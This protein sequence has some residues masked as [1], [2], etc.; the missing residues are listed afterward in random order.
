MPAI[1]SFNP[2]TDVNTS[3]DTITISNHGFNALDGVIYRNGGGTSVG[4]LV[5]GTKYYVIVV[6]TNNLKLA[7][8]EVK[9]RNS[10]VV[11]ILNTGAGTVHT[12]EFTT[13]FPKE[14]AVHNIFQNIRIIGTG[15][16]ADGTTFT[17]ETNQDYLNIIG[18]AGV[19]FTAIDT[20]SKT[21]TL[22]ATQYDF[23]VPLGTT[24]LRLFSDSGDDQ[25]IILTPARGIAITRVGSQELEFESFGVTETDTLQT[26]TQRGSITNQDL[27]M[28]NLLVAKVESIP[29]VDGVVNYTTTGTTGTAIALTGNGTLDFPLLFSPDYFTSTETDKDIY[30]NFQSPAAQGTLSYTAVYQTEST[31]TTGSVILQRND[32]GG[33]VTI[34]NIS[35]TQQDQSYTIDGN[36]AELSTSTIDYR[37]VFSWTG[38]SDIVTSRVRVTYELENVPG[39]EII[40][41]DTDNEVLTLGTLNGF[42]NIRGTVTF[43]DELNTDGLRLYNNN[44]SSINSDSNIVIVPAG[45]GKLE[46]RNSD[47]FSTEATVNLFTTVDTTTINI[48][49]LDGTPP[50]TSTNFRTNVTVSGDLN[51]DGGDITTNQ[52][53]FNLLNTNATTINAFGAAETINLGDATATQINIGSATTDINLGNIDINGNTIDTNDSTGITFTPV[54]TFNTDVNAENDL[55]VTQDFFVGK[56]SFLT[57]NLTVQENIIVVGEI[58]SPTGSFNLL[59]QPN[60][61]T[62][63]S[64]ANAVSIGAATGTTTVQHSLV[65]SG[66]ATVDGGNITTNQTTFNL[67]NTNAT[68]VNFAGAG[69]AIAIGAGT[70]TTNFKHNVD[71][72]LDLNVD[73]GD[74]TTNQTA[75]NLLNTTATTVNAFGAATALNLGATTGNTV[76]NNTLQVSNIGTTDSSSL[77]LLTPVVANSSLDVDTD[78]TVGQDVTIGH[79]LVVGG[80]L[81]VQGTQTILN[82]STL[83]VEDLNITLANGASSAFEASGAG[84]TVNA[85][86][87][88]ITYNHIDDSWNLNK[89]LNATDLSVSGTVNATDLS[90]SGT[91]TGITATMVGLGNVTNESKTTMF[92]SPTFTGTTTLQQSTEVLNTKAGA[93][94]VVVHDFSTG[95]IWYHTAISSNFTANFTNVPTTADRT[96]SVVLILVQGGT[97]YLPTAVQIDGVTQTINWSGGFAPTPVIN[98]IDIVSFNLLRVGSTWTV[99]GAGTTYG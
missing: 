23:E 99:I 97:A 81:T 14:T 34:D 6:D 71:I 50:T 30:V 36:Y 86:N 70:G 95:S 76:V 72:D 74:I 22:N 78:L 8:S 19:N 41:T 27:T 60:T 77:T 47:V 82:T 44:I 12:L 75:F 35:G 59:N 63:F 56:N 96:I 93:T 58:T 11:D 24:N 61:V 9:A 79:N 62:A 3:T 29:G 48:G 84:I 4:G 1:K 91:A 54:V 94:G 68:T 32:G 85:A 51:V 53:T 16:P 66:D 73:G 39:T 98:Q 38:S 92:T 69:T 25:S 43:A 55:R 65:V 88:T 49:Y 45:T 42:V 57:G 40:L 21:F 18:G 90:I 89:K 28:N 7:T 33:W 46:L 31:L 26:V 87:A 13:I 15:T 37:L 80:D 10:Q 2:S 67:I 20:D 17:A 52:T 83:S 64:N 5:H